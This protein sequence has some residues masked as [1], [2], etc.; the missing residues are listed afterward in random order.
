MA[1]DPN[2]LGHWHDLIDNF[3]ASPQEFYRAFEQA[4]EERRVP[5]LHS[6]RVEHKEGNLTSARRQYLRMHR[7]KYAFD[8][9]AAPF[10]TGFFV[11]SWFTQPPL[12]FGI[13]YTL[14]FLLATGVAAMILST[15]GLAIGSAISGITVGT[16]LGGLFAMFGT[17]LL[18]WLGG[19]AVRHGGIPGESTL[20]AMPLIGWIYEKIFAPPTFYSMDTALMFEESVKRAVGH[21]IAMMTDGKGVRAFAESAEK[22]LM[23]PF[24]PSM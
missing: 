19:T 21:V 13:L 7:G 20:L 6:A 12:E 1:K 14:A 15:M 3:Q 23:P 8:I 11:S 4:L 22:P 2:V 9:C 10:G 16:M 17:P 18:L 5:E 24:V